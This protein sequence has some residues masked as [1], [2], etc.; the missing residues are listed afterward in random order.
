MAEIWDGELL[1][2]SKISGP[3][4]RCFTRFFYVFLAAQLLLE[5]LVK[6]SGVI[7]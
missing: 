5:S 2:S 6:F 4:E 3:H 1:R 7:G